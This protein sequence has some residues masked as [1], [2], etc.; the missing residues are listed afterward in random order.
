M[1]VNKNQ[2]NFQQQKKFCRFCVD[3]N[4]IIDYKNTKELSK[5]VSSFGKI[6]PRRKTGTC[7]KH[8][9]K[10]A[11]AIKRARFMALM[12]FINR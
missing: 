9:R 5:L 4:K 2:D 6:L 11:Q 1:F 8:H 12:P 3:K 10:V 7:A